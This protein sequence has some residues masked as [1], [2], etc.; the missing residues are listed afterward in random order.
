MCTKAFEKRQFCPNCSHSWDD[1]HFQRVQRQIRWQQAHL[2][3]KRGRKRK[4][5][6]PNATPNYPS[7][8]TPASLPNEDP[9]PEIAKVNPTW[10]HPE[11]SQWGYTEV[12]M[13]T[14]DSC[15][16]WV[17]AGCAG[18]DED[19]YEQTSNGDHPIYSK[20]FL[21]RICCRK[22]CLDL[23]QKLQEEDTMMLFAEPVTDRVAH[24]YHDVIKNPMD[25]QTMLIRAEREE[26]KNY[27][28]CAKCLS[29]W[30]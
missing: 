30:C 25:L 11:T 17:H 24:N 29:L 27:S 26:Y 22:R 19:E 3:K 9:F 2:P 6:D 14:C 21:C 23:I 5:E 4:Y 12:D 10:Y 16:L 8:T 1:E 15:K 28:G 20:E 18:V 7:F 13:L